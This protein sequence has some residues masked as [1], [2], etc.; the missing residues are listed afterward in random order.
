[1]IQEK[2]S[3]ELIEHYFFMNRFEQ[4]IDLLPQLLE[5]ESENAYLW[6]LFGYSSYAL[7]HYEE[8]EEQ[9]FEALRLGAAEEILFYTLGRLYSETEQWQKSEDMFLETL[10]LNPNN[11]EAHAHYALLM[12]KTGNK[13]KAKLLIERA[14]ELDPE[15]AEALRLHF[16]IEGV[17]ESRKEQI[18]ALEQYVNSEDSELTK[19]LRLGVDATFRNNVKEAKEYFRQAFLLQPEDKELLKTLEE[20]EIASHPLLAPNRMADKL[21]GPAGTWF[22]GVG[23]TFLLFLIG[24]EQV[25]FVWVVCY[26]VLASYTWIS[27]PLVKMLRKVRG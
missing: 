8:A 20:F 27:E 12:K 3:V 26:A 6:Y 24:L 19:L 15:D 25:A 14:L 13:K 2:E 4:V 1:M 17:N 22:I 5:E 21:G 10:R 7:D 23:M 9:L 11:V 18:L 16:Y